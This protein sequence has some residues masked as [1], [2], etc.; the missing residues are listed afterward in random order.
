MALS[1]SD[2]APDDMTDCN[3]KCCCQKRDSSDSTT[4]IFWSFFCSEDPGLQEQCSAE[5]NKSSELELAPTI[6]P[7]EPTE[8]AIAVPV[9]RVVYGF[10]VC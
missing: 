7:R 10:C 5:K 1:K 4:E 2:L 6:P 3:D 9:A 8:I